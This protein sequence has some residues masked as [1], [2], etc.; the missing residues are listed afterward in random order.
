MHANFLKTK[1][2]I[3][4]IIQSRIIAITTRRSLICVNATTSSSFAFP[5]KLLPRRDNKH[6][7]M[8]D[9]PYYFMYL[10]T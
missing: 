5:A 10:Y 6:S 9:G 8:S 3:P 7:T 1:F 2:N 4:H